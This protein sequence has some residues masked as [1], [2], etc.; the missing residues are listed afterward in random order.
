MKY[1]VMALL[2][3][4]AVILPSFYFY[5]SKIDFKIKIF[6]IISGSIL[7]PLSIFINI[8][9][10]VF[11]IYILLITLYLF[12]VNKKNIYFIF[13]FISFYFIFTFV[14]AFL[15]ISFINILK[16]KY[17]Q[18][19]NNIY[20]Q[21]AINIS[22][23]IFNLLF[24]F[25]IKKLKNLFKLK[26]SIIKE[27]KKSFL[28]MILN[29]I[30]MFFVISIMV[31]LANKNTDFN[32]KYF[33]FLSWFIIIFFVLNLITCYMVINYSNKEAYIKFKIKEFEAVN[34]YTKTLEE[35][36]TE[37]RKFRHDYVNMLS[38][39]F[40]YLNENDINGLKIFF[41]KNIL[42][43]GESMNKKNLRIGLLGNIKVPELKGILISKIIK[44]Q[45]LGID[46]FVEIPES[47]NKIKIDVIDLARV[48]GIIMDNAVEAALESKEKVVRLGIFGNKE[49]VNLVFVN[50][51]SNKEIYLSEILKEGFSTKGTGRG[52]GLNILQ[53]IINNH[54]NVTLD[55]CIEKDIF[56]QDLSIF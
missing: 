51:Y 52:L 55:T 43:L 2:N 21:F 33:Y 15:A 17:Q 24:A 13:Y 53:E 18:I 45:E 3:F 50:S 4:G 25:I 41:E 10:I 46:V 9:K 7:F 32:N 34:E 22:L 23:F 48:I 6:L 39:M 1:T 19:L 27:N 36:N 16:E 26:F 11:P 31:V 35:V 40:E 49:S 14:E 28:L 44:A 54:S 37:V 38:T 56:I 8:N 20:V 42:P 5:K 29:L 47:I 30:I 12:L